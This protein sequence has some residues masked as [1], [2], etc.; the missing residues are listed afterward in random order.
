MVRGSPRRVHPL[1]V[2]DDQPGILKQLGCF[3]QQHPVLPRAVGDRR[4]ERLA[5]HLVGHL[6]A[7]GLQQGYLLRARLAFGHQVGVLEHRMGTFIRPVHEI[8]VG[9]FEIERIDQ[10]FT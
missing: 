8:L 10:R 1:A 9:P 5:E 2:L 6:A 3:A 4:H 7:V